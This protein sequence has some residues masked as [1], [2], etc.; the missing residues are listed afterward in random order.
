M[1][2]VFKKDDNYVDK[3]P[4]NTYDLSFQNNLTTNFGKLVPVLCQEVLPG[5][6]F[7]IKP[8]F[9]L[10]FMPQVFPVQTRMRAHI[11][12]FYVR[13]R[14]LWK[15]WMDFIGRTK[16]GLVPPYLQLSKEQCKKLRPSSLYDYLGLPTWLKAENK[17]VYAATP[18]YHINCVYDWT[19]GLLKTGVPTNELYTLNATN[20]VNEISRVYY[21]YTEPK[22]D[23]HF[24]PRTYI[25][26]KPV[27]LPLKLNGQEFKLQWRYKSTVD[28]NIYTILKMQNG[29]VVVYPI[30]STPISQVKTVGSGLQY[31]AKDG[32]TKRSHIMAVLGYF[33]AD[34]PQNL[35]LGARYSADL[36]VVTNPNLYNGIPL[37]FIEPYSIPICNEVNTDGQRVSA[38]PARAYQ[39]IFN[40]F[41]RNAEVTPFIR[42]GV[43]EYNV[44]VTND[45]GGADTTDYELYNR[46]WSDD[47]FT[48]CRVSPQ[49]GDAPLVGLTG[50][51]G[52]TFTLS[53]DDGTTSKL[54]LQVDSSTG[55]VI[56]VQDTNDDAAKELSDAINSAINY[57]ITINDLRNVN[58]FQ[59]WLE[60][61][62]RIGFKYRDQLMSHYGV[63]ARYDTLQMPEFIGG[64]SRD[65]VVNQISQ[66]VQTE[67]DGNLGDIAGQ[68]GV[69][70]SGNDVECYCD[71]H[72][73]IIGIMSVV[74]APM[75]SQTMP[76]HLMK[77]DAFDYFFP[78]F[79][80]IGFQPILNK[81][82]SFVQSYFE[83]KPDEVFGYQRAWS[84][85]LENLDSVHGLFQSDLKN[86]LV[87]RVF[88]STPQLSGDFLY[89]NNKDLNN[90][91]Y[92]DDDNDKILGQI[93][94]DIKAKR[95]IPLYG[96]PELD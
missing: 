45:D 84:E 42:N 6:S 62:N 91:F 17:D 81:E 59:K 27:M 70:G 24:N 69:V 36:N 8:T 63:K 96:I 18:D 31:T 16:E 87:G 67:N 10:R 74:P 55:K 64:V 51:Q 1:A 82:L 66:T 50:V 39:A 20:G 43:R 72:G 3:K 34:A 89:V 29:D 46:P 4:R 65:V 73:F 44:Y 38:L 90:I 9:G 57:G 7:R 11:H 79:G 85:Y 15:D 14:T 2:S 92:V 48:T 68:A 93:Y 83:N 95:Q 13:N 61:K 26:E 60:N 58:S 23:H 49:A 75:Y 28:M 5:D 56:S 41:Y 88:G 77:S 25:F 86:F 78:E 19:S 30:W 21:K 71:E 33:I 12:Y 53:D 35:P 76:K 47:R 22:E 32:S 54:R 80:K 40:S 52:A 94:H 37:S